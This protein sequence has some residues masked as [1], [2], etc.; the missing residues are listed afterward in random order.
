M[1]KISIIGPKEAP[2]FKPITNKIS[3]LEELAVYTFVMSGKAYRLTFTPG[4]LI[5]GASIPRACWTPLGLAPHGIMD[6]PALPHDGGYGAQGHFTVKGDD[7]EWIP[8]TMTGG[9]K[10][11]FEVLDEKKG[12]TLCTEPMTKSELDELLRALCVHFGID[13]FR[14]RTV[15]TA[16]RGFGFWAWH[17]NSDEYK[18]KHLK[19][20]KAGIDY[21]VDNLAA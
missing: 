10:S 13:E 11:I 12:W 9:S 20:T 16:V 6:A 1:D 7:G 8:A 4:F 19:K 18:K 17:R 15:W 21:L 14:A 2:S 5:D 3:R